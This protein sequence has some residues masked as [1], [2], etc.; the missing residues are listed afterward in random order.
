MDKLCRPCGGAFV[1]W[2][3]SRSVVAVLTWSQI[4]R[5]HGDDLCFS[6]VSHRNV[7]EEVKD[8]SSS[9]DDMDS[10]APVN[11]IVPEH[12][13]QHQ[14][15]ETTHCSFRLCPLCLRLCSGYSGHIS[16]VII[17]SVIYFVFCF[18]K[19]GRL[20]LIKKNSFRYWLSP[21]NQNISFSV[22]LV[23]QTK[24]EVLKCWLSPSNQDRILSGTGSVHQTKIE[25]FRIL[26]QSIK[27]N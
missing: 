18:F 20:R 1:S 9:D 25:F 23:H 13:L 19:R 17:P 24:I 11:D 14:E 10:R 22:G 12:P 3:F 21:S 7:K 8:N 27:T 26:S 2:T 6:D 4:C 15:G 16:F 5:P